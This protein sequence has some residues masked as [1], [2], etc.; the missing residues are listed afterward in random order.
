MPSLSLTRRGFLGGSAAACSLGLY[1]PA[2]AAPPA[3]TIAG[4]HIEVLGRAFTAHGRFGPDWRSGIT[5]TAGARFQGD[6]LNTTPGGVITHWHGQVLAAEGQ[7]RAYTGGGELAPGQSDRVDFELTP[8]TH[9]MHAH[10]LSEQ[11]LMAAPMIGREAEAE[12][13]QEVVLMLHDFS[14][15]SPGEILAELGASM[16]HGHGAAAGMDHAGMDMGEGEG[17]GE[18]EG[19]NMAEGMAGMVHANDVVYDAFLANDRTLSDPE[20][21]AVEAGAR[22]RLRIINAATATAFWI[23]PGRLDRAAVAVDGSPC[24]P[25][26]AAAYPLSQGQRLDLMVTVPREGWAFA[27]LAQVEAPRRSTRIVL[28]APWSA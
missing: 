17:E 27:V 12:A 7:D 4:R 18:G 15:R 10:Q 9:W 19:M 24:Q 25:H 16:T 22:L 26:A 8:G 14:F 3:L 20:V 6:V 23:D 1:R 5:A 11:Q 13:M 28:A 21:I 2:H